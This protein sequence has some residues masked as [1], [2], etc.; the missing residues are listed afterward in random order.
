MLE[1]GTVLND[2]YKIVDEIDRGGMSVVYLA[3]NER[4][5]SAWAVKEIRKD[6]E[7]DSK[8]VTQSL[9]TERDI[10]KKLNHEHI[11]KIADVIETEDTFVIVMEFI[12]GQSLGRIVSQSGAQAPDDV[13]SWAK[14]LA[15]VLDYLH[16]KRPPIIYRD[17]KPGNIMLKP[18]G[19][20]VLCDFGTAKE[21][22]ESA[23]GDTSSLGTYAYSAPEQRVAGGKSDVR[24]DIYNLGAT[25]YHL[26]TGKSPE[27]T[28]DQICRLGDICPRFSGTGWEIIIGKCCAPR[29]GD[30]YQNCAE[31]K[32]ALDH[33]DDF[34]AEQFRRRKIRWR[35]FVAACAIAVISATGT[36]AFGYGERSLRSG[37]YDNYLTRARSASDFGAM[38]DNYEKA[39]DLRPESADAYEQL[40]DAIEADMAFTQEEND[41]LFR[42]IN[43]YNGGSRTNAER[44]ASGDGEAYVKFACRLANDYFFLYEGTDH[45]AKGA[46]WYETVRDSRY[47]GGQ[48]REL[49]R[50]LGTIGKNY[51][52][53][54][55]KDANPWLENSY[56]YRDYWDQLVELTDGDVVAKTGGTRYAVVLFYEFADQIRRFSTDFKSY[57]ITEEEMTGQLDKLE[58]GL[59]AFEPENG[60][61]KDKIGDTYDCIELA[62]D[63]VG[64]A[65]EKAGGRK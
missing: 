14:Q 45:R 20:I 63:M 54:L 25:L 64:I 16:S 44:F 53:M 62:R 10:L 35:L 37:I 36:L 43:S 58:E 32:F 23:A 2:T 1:I 61:V 31:L 55:A 60:I 22:R 34:G 12:E 7:I 33:I 51:E 56:D 18:S 30:R 21:F 65:F 57:G 38:A 3:R 19:S 52:K 48:E 24:T 41:V 59:A 49:A 5:N 15:D 47:L 29:P 9:I 13:L 42:V 26:L 11:L 39:I 40:L 17:M 6:S 50:A 8:H 46:Q 28:Y 27:E 4:A